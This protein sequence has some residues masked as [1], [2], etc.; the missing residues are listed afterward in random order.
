[1]SNKLKT[2]L[3]KM[4]LAFFKAVLQYLPRVTEENR[5]QLNYFQAV[6]DVCAPGYEF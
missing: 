1:M 2:M 4:F 3:K 6:Y 5:W